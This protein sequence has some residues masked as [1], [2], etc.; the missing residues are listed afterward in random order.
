M[1]QIPDTTATN[2]F[3]PILKAFFSCFKNISTKALIGIVRATCKLKQR[4]LAI[5]SIQCLF[6]IREMAAFHSSCVFPLVSLFWSPS[7]YPLLSF[8]RY[9]FGTNARI[10]SPIIQEHVSRQF[11]PDFLRVHFLKVAKITHVRKLASVLHTIFVL[12]KIIKI[13][14]CSI[15]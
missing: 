1:H 14:H 15:I 11:G 13:A 12:I 5:T 3:V 6:V 4:L 10:S 7:Y 2:A 8:S 9:Y